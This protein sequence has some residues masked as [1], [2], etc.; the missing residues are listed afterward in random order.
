MPPALRKRKGSSGLPSSVFNPTPSSPDTPSHVAHNRQKPTIVP[1]VFFVIVLGCCIALIPLFYYTQVMIPDPGSKSILSE[2]RIKGNILL[3]A[4]GH[5]SSVGNGRLA[6]SQDPFE[7]KSSLSKLKNSISKHPP[8]SSIPDDTT[9]NDPQIK[10]V[11][12]DARLEEELGRFWKASSEYR[13]KAQKENSGQYSLQGDGTIRSSKHASS[14]EIS[15]DDLPEA[16][17]DAKEGLT[18]E[19]WEAIKEQFSADDLTVMLDSM[20]R[21]E[22]NPQSSTPN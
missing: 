13:Q 20:R 22:K 3:N 17:P 9:S 6:F 10:K 7:A 21:K 14:D 8:Q 12:E 5:T 2:F 11:E 4:L 19:V 16:D 18:P 15:I 1:S